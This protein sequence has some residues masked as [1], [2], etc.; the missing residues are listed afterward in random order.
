M[1]LSGEEG[2]KANPE[3]GLACRGKPPPQM[4]TAKPR[5]TARPAAARR[6][7]SHLGSDIQKPNMWIRNN[8][9]RRLESG[10]K[11]EKTS[12]LRSEEWRAGRQDFER[13]LRRGPGAGGEGRD[14]PRG[15]LR[16]EPWSS[17]TAVL[18]LVR[19]NLDG[20]DAPGSPCRRDPWGNRGGITSK[21]QP[22]TTIAFHRRR[23]SSGRW[24][25]IQGQESLSPTSRSR[26][27]ELGDGGPSALPAGSAEGGHVRTGEVHPARGGTPGAASCVGKRCQRSVA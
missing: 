21:T 1:S 13:G 11:R 27:T 17:A 24:N 23:W 9:E 2:T 22:R 14:R 6:C 18:K 20:E 15:R 3:R 26:R 8:P 25:N 5:E 12:G 7:E 4:E 19:G 10:G 16:Q